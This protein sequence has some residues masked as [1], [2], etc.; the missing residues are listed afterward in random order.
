[1]LLA[2]GLGQGLL[3]YH[4]SLKEKTDSVLLRC[5]DHPLVLYLFSTNEQIQKD[6]Q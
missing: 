5:R 3:F 1:M 2:S 6:G 4:C